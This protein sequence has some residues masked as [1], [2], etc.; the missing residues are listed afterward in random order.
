MKLR[1][2]L[3]SLFTAALTLSSPGAQPKLIVAIVV[4]QL[5]YDYLERFHDQFTEGGFRMLTDRGAFLTFAHYDHVPTA[6]GPG[7]ATALS[8]TPPAIHG[9]IANDWFDKRTLKMVNCVSDPDVKGV[10][11]AEKD[12]QRSP[13]NFIGSNFADELR[14]RFHS[15]VVGISLKDRGAILPAGKKPVGAYWFDSNSGNFITSTYYMTDLPAWVREFN[16]RKRP[17]AFVGQTWK[18]LLDPKLYDWPDLAAGEGTMAREKTP[19]FD[20]TVFPSPTEGFE[21]IVPTPFGNQLL[22]EFALAAIDGES[23]GTGPQPDLLCISFSA[24]DAAGHR[25]GPYSQEVQ[26][27]TLRLDRDLAG[28]FSVLDKKL[29]LANVTI[30]LTADHGVAPTPEFAVEQSLGGGRSDA[31]PLMADLLAKMSERF[32]PGRYFISPRVVDGNL[33]FNHDTLREKQLPAEDVADFIREWAL[34]TGK[35]HT[36]YSRRQLLEGLAPGPLGRRFVNG[37]N[38]ER[39]GDVVLVYKPFILPAPAKTGTTH[40][41]PFAYDTHVPVLLYGSTFIPGR[42]A[43]EFAINDLV[44]TL[45]AALHMNEPSGSTGKPL[46]RLLTGEG[47]TAAPKATGE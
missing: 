34:S 1:F 44:P 43:D 27:M 42:Y 16:D 18:R 14:L 17:A 37:Y 47:P 24:I 22:A 6:T 40:G 3:T 20:H 2:L 35:F 11:G 19:T 25:F 23:L 30:A 31:I 41:G 12:G 4:D 8:G 10:G 32:G 28:L 29:G 38:A 9:I 26:D 21:T 46:V 33:Y 13:R 36:A 45:C 39:S 5:R 15:K 7:H